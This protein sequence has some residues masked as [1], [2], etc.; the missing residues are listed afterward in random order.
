MS[1][2]LL[3][4]K[5]YIPPPRANFVPRQR[6][7]ERLNQGLAGK[8]ILISA[9]AGFGKS[10][11]LSEWA[12]HVSHPVAWISLR[13]TSYNVCYTKLLRKASV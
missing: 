1:I 5:L 12:T 6:L 10:T 11:L 13:I 3:T 7:I 9:P 8:L 2:T 4:T